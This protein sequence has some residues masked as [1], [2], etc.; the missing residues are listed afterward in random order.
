MGKSMQGAGGA[1][2]FGAVF[3]SIV[4]RTKSKKVFQELTPEEWL[5]SNLEEM[6]GIFETFDGTMLVSLAMGLIEETSGV[7]HFV[8]AEHPWMVLYRDKKAS[9]L[10]ADVTYRKLG[11]LGASPAKHIKVINLQPND[12]LFA[13]SDGK[14][15]ILFKQENG[16]WEINSDDELFLKLVEKTD[17]NLDSLVKEILSLGKVID[18]IS[19]IRISLKN[20]K[21][22]VNEITES[23]KIESKI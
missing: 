3:Q 5:S 14:D 23:I 21:K 13:G 16:E 17:G 20:G 9:F 8:N 22:N 12:I 15:D 19:L 4:Q 11:T 6:H 18:D 1:L 10:Y 7:L 2:V